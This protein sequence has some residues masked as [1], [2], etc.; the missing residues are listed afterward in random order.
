V[1]GKFLSALRLRL[2]TLLL[3][4]AGLA[5]LWRG[6]TRLRRKLFGTVGILL[7]SLLYAALIIWVLMITTG[8]QIEWRGGFPPVLTYSKTLPNYDAVD[9]S[10]AAQHN[11]PTP[12]ITNAAALPPYWTDFR[13]PNRD[14]HYDETPILTNW[15]AA[16]LRELWRQPIGGGYASFV[17]AEGLAFTIEQRRDFEVAAAYDLATGLEVWTNGWPAHFQESMGGE[18]PRAT[19]TYHNGNLYV[20]GAAGEF[21]CFAAATGKTVWSRNVLTDTQTSLLYFGMA[22]SPLVVDDKVIVQAGETPGKSLAAY[23]RTTG[24]ILWKALDDS[25]AY[26]SPMLVLLA[27]QRQLL[28]A[29]E[30]RVVG[31]SVESGDLLWEH[32]WVVNLKNRNV[33]Q[34]VLLG[35]NRF[36]LSAGYGTGAEAIEIT[37]TA[38]GFSASTIWKNKFLKNKFTSSVFWNGFIFGLDEDMLTCLNAETGERQWK[39]GRYGYGQLLVAGGCLIILSGEGELALVRAVPDR[40]EELARFPA[41]HGKT[42]NHPVIAHGKLLVR[43]AV[44][45]ACYD[46]LPRPLN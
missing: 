16:G 13:G 46:L 30:K 10:R 38:S 33:A 15:P 43:N 2:W 23:D 20:Q 18:G 22:A 9:K 3:P 39:D 34:P 28:V 11:L 12:S 1:P 40:Y 31:L 21:R 5:L 35:T 27:G 45:M 37:K 19:P 26:G 42:W 36:M 41:I 24:A 14:G 7:Y 6:P 44:E 25:G 4:P 32:P 29:T 8:L 17:V